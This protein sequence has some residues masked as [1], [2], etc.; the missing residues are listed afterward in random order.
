MKLTVLILVTF[1]IAPVAS[2]GLRSLRNRSPDKSNEGSE[3]A[4]AVAVVGERELLFTWCDPATPALWHPNYAGA[5]S[6]AR[7]TFKADCDSTGYDTELVCCNG[8]Y[9][10]QVSVSCKGGFANPSTTFSLDEEG[11]KREAPLFLEEE[12]NGVGTTPPHRR[13]LR[14]LLLEGK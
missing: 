12:L 11:K 13:G 1:A 3:A 8:A 5:W 4:I 7:C 6:T 10:G 14:R 9:G 2:L